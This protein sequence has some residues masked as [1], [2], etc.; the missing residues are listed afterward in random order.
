MSETVPAAS[1]LPDSLTH[2]A[3][4]LRD[5]TDSQHVAFGQ[6]TAQDELVVIHWPKQASANSLT[7]RAHQIPDPWRAVGNSVGAVTLN[8]PHHWLSHG[9]DALESR[10]NRSVM[11]PVRHRHR[12]LGK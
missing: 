11:A 1:V 10:V 12:T 3:G 9:D 5:S 8:D 7:L 6:W 2:L 4:H